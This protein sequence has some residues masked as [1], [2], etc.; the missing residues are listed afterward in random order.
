MR[1]NAPGTFHDWHVAMRR[2]YA[3]TLAGEEEI[4]V[5]GGQKVHFGP[6]DIELAEDT[7]GKGHLSRTIGKVDHLTV[8]LPVA[9]EPSR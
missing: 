9:D 6:G 1:R 5:A 8:M 7:T 4:E 2:Q 3:I